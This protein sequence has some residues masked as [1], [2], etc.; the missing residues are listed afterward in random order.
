MN[1]LQLINDLKSIGL[2]DNQIF[3]IL[4]KDVNNSDDII[5]ISLILN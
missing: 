5:D 4:N 3:Y 2:S 1:K